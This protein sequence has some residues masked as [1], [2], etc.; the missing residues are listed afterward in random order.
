MEEKTYKKFDVKRIKASDLA[1]KMNEL[2]VKEGRPNVNIRLGDITVSRKD[3]KDGVTRAHIEIGFT[4]DTGWQLVSRYFSTDLPTDEDFDDLKGRIFVDALMQKGWNEDEGKWGALK[5][6]S[7]IT[8]DGETFDFS[9]GK[10]PY[11]ADE[12]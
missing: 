12:E 5:V 7:L 9:G 11:R 8:S 10:E 4:D 1:V 2:D 6:R 3:C